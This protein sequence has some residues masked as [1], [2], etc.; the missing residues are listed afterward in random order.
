VAEKWTQAFGRYLRTLRERRGLSLQ[1]VASLS[2]PFAEPVTKGYL[3]RAE[4]GRVRLALSK[5][6]ALNHIYKVSAEVLLER[7][8]LDMEL[9]R[10]GGPETEGM[11]WIELREAGRLA[12]QR[13]LRWEAYAYLRRATVQASVEAVAC[14]YRDQGEQIACAGM[15][16]ATAALGLGRL[17]FALHEYRHVEGNALLGPRYL[18]LV[19]ER[20]AVVL[21][22]L[23]D[24]SRAK[25][26]AD[27][28]IAAAKT[29]DGGGYLGHAYSTRSVLAL[30]ES[31]LEYAAA[32]SQMSFR[33]FKQAGRTSECAT[34][35]TNL[36]QIY[37]DLGRL[38]AARRALR[39]TE[40]LLLPAPD[41]QRQRA[42]GRI[43]LGEI[44][45]RENRDDF[46]QQ[47]WKEA[48][49]IARE[50]H[51]KTLQFK[52]EYQLLR[53][54]HRRGLSQV[55]RSIGRR[56]SRLSNYVPESTPELHSFRDFMEKDGVVAS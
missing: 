45:S 46:A 8:D 36:A 31:D 15:G 24:L 14:D 20:L 47:S 17:R 33:W 9:D 52:A 41:H 40:S 56:L 42:L 34:E 16:C 43:L 11:S 26:Y 27:R 4:N 21:R 28:A 25:D 48:A 35:L 37:F 1:D 53:Y 29:V 22:R 50:L 54:A 6:A 2:Q 38:G 3:S 51:D 32:L 23:N 10:I 44:D 30:A 7:I 5:V 18:P 49:E 19:F 13:G 39:A 12:F 55:A